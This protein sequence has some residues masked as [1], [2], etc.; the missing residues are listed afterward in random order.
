[1]GRKKGSKNGEY[2]FIKCICRICGKKEMVF[3][4][5]KKI[6]CSKKCV[7][8]SKMGKSPWNKG[9]KG[10]MKAWNKN[11]EL[12]EKHRKNL[13]KSWNRN[14]CKRHW[15]GGKTHHTLGYIYIYKTNHPFRDYRKYVFEHRLVMEKKLGRYLRP[16][17]VIHH[18]NGIKTDNRI[19]N[20][21]LFPNNVA[22]MKFH[23]LNRI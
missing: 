6:Y 21:M 20:L 1:M 23:K 8:K 4:S 9:T 7:G 15:K 14:F 19:K 12:S 10:I 3:P 2:I 17:E 22:H 13:S 16:E 18:I 11:K 5:Q